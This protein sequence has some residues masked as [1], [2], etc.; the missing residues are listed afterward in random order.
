MPRATGGVRGLA[1]WRR[2]L[3]VLTDSAEQHLRVAGRIVA[4]LEAELAR[5]TGQDDLGVLRGELTALVH[6]M[7]DGSPPPLRPVW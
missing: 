4:E 1:A 5:R 7:S 3:V 6:A 2:R